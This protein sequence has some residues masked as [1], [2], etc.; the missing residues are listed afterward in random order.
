MPDLC[1]VFAQPIAELWADSGLARP[2]PAQTLQ[3]GREL[4]VQ[5]DSGGHDLPRSVLLMTSGGS[6]P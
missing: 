4:V 3:F 6:P 5:S 2:L 1:D